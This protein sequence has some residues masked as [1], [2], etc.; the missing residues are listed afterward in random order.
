[1]KDSFRSRGLMFVISSP[2]G[3]GKTTLAEALL[4]KDSNLERSISI[5]TRPKR[6]EEIDG[7]D[8]FFITEDKYRQMVSDDLLLEHAQV[9]SHFYGTPKEHVEKLLN[10]GN[11]VVCV[12]DWQGGVNLMQKARQDTISAFILPPS[13]EELKIRLTNRAT[14]ETEVV[15]RR[16]AAA[17]NEISK[18]DNYDYV[19]VNNK[20]DDCVAQLR[21]IL[22]AERARGSRQELQELIVAIESS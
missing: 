8:Y 13:L 5:T 18:C 15:H 4:S 16:L 12:I 10:Q 19:V 14:D 20:F 2:S 11:D 21:A 7:K 9:F 17:K 6:K 1:M 22:D 3:C